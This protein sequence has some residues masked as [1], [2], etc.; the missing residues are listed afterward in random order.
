MPEL[1]RGT[2]TFLFTEG[3]LLDG[4][5]LRSLGSR[6]LRDLHE[7]EVVFQ[8]I[9]EGLP[10]QFPPLLSFPR[11]PTDLTAPPT[12]LVGWEEETRGRSPVQCLLLM[13]QHH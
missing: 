8:V 6:R 2:V 7:P 9:A 10:E 13:D 12:P 11:H 4:M 1:P 5:S 3:T